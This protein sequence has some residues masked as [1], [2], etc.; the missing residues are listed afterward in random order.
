MQLLQPYA[1]LLFGLCLMWLVLPTLKQEAIHALRIFFWWG[2]LQYIGAERIRYGIEQVV[3]Y[4]L[5][6]AASYGGPG[7]SRTARWW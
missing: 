2:V 1:G 3:Q 5:K 6:E 4:I 7:G